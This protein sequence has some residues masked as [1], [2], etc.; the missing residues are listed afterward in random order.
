MTWRHETH[1]SD[2]PDDDAD[3]RTGR[4]VTGINYRTWTAHSENNEYELFGKVK[5]EYELFGKVK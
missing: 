1:K 2:K 3:R 4:D 5:Y